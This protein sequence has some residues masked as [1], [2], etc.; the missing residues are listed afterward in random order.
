MGSQRPY[1]GN[2]IPGEPSSQG[3]PRSKCYEMITPG[4]TWGKSWALLHSGLFLCRDLRS[5]RLSLHPAAPSALG[6][7]SLLLPSP[8]ICPS[9]YDPCVPGLCPPSVPCPELKGVRARYGPR[10]VLAPSLLLSSPSTFALTHKTCIL[11]ATE[12][13]SCQT[14]GKPKASRMSHNLY[15]LL[16]GSLR[17]PT[18]Y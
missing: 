18:A 16:S 12:K 8:G 14:L 9:P 1:Q 4:V 3:V 10:V 5:C 7:L 17:H 2:P 11:E 13:M 15:S 6:L